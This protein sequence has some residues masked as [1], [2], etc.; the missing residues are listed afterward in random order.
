MTNDERC[1]RKIASDPSCCACNYPCETPLHVLSDCQVACDFWHQVLLVA[2]IRSFFECNLQQWISCTLTTTI[3]YPQ[4]T[5]PWKLLFASLTWQIWKR[6][7]DLIFH[8]P[9]AISDTTIISRNI[10]WAKY[11]S[12]GK[13]VS[14]AS[15]S[16]PRSRVMDR[17][18]LDPDWIYLNVDGAISLSLSDGSIGGLSLAWKQGFEKVLVRSDSKQVVDLVNSPSA[19]SSVLSLTRAIHRLRQKSWATIVCWIPRDDNR[20]ANAI[21]KLVNSSD[22]SLH[23]YQDPLLEV[24]LLLFNDKNRL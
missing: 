14:K 3:C 10:V 8:S 6:R 7:N 15:S 23:V 22:Y 19:A 4:S 24:D 17:D 5:L 2:L 21:A 13:T 16:S 18:V 9:D 12:D 1:R 20:H 11:Y